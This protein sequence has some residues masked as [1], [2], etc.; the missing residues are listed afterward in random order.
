MLCLLSSAHEMD[1]LRKETVSVSGRSGT[2]SSVALTRRKQ[3]KEGVCWMWGVQSDFDQP[4][5]TL[6]ISTVPGE[7]GGLYQRFAQ[8]SG[9]PSVVF[10]G[11][12]WKLS[13][14]R[15]ILAYR[16]RIQWWQSRTVSVAP[17][18]GW[19]SSAGE[20]STASAGP[21]SMWLSQFRSWKM[22]LPRNLNDSTHSVGGEQGVSPEVHD[23]LH[24]FERVKLQVVTTAPDASSLTSCL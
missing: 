12:I 16:G 14:T 19:T 11:Q 9:L 15:Q 17:V 23:H 4:F 2:Q 1:C 13:W 24:S 7:W 22:V 18:A 10:W 3:F 21:F 5:C 20:G 8:Q 6:W